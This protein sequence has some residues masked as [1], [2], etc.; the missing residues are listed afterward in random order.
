MPIFKVFGRKY[1]DYYTS[2]T[3]P[4]EQIAYDYALNNDH[5]QWFEIEGDDPIEP[6]D[7]FLD[8]YTSDEDLQLN[9]DIENEW[10]DMTSGIVSTGTN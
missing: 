6:Y 9:K 2:V 1:I 3:A 10:P 5:I 7:V 4:D 8:E